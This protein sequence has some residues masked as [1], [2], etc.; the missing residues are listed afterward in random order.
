MAGR[1]GGIQ[2]LLSLSSYIS[3]HNRP[4]IERPVLGA[5]NN[6]FIWKA[7]KARR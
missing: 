7:S 5:R 6:D 4:V 3:P 2:A 1:L